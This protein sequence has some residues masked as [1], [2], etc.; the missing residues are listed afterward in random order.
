MYTVFAAQEELLLLW[1]TQ[2]FSLSHDVELAGG[3][4]FGQSLGTYPDEGYKDIT[5]RKCPAL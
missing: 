1:I 2:G 4:S 3:S 5:N